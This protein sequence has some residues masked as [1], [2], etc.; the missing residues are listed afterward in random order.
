[1]RSCGCSVEAMHGSTDNHRSDVAPTFVL[2]CYKNS[3]P[4]KQPVKQ[5]VGV[6]ILPGSLCCLVVCPM[7]PSRTSPS[8]HGHNDGKMMARLD[9]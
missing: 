4:Q 2:G 3:T 7:R 5:K 6:G 9:S 8:K 1:M